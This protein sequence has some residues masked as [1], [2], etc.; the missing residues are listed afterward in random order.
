[1]RGERLPGSGRRRRGEAEPNQKGCDSPQDSLYC[2]EIKGG[3]KAA[4]RRREV[5]RVIAGTAEPPGPEHGLCDE[6]SLCAAKILSNITKADTLD[7]YL[8]FAA[9]VSKQR[10]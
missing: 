5:S 2:K 7:V 4:H 3:W 10:H 6:S 9:G 8:P 1:M